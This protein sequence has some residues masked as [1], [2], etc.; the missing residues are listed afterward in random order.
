VL[1]YR[2]VFFADRQNEGILSCKWMTSSRWFVPWLCKDWLRNQ[3]DSHPVTPNI[4]GMHLMFLHSH[5]MNLPM[6]RAP[7]M[8][9]RPFLIVFTLPIRTEKRIRCIHRP[10]IC[11]MVGRYTNAPKDSSKRKSLSSD[12]HVQPVYKGS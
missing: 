8:P 11:I 12:T 5:Y 2:A 4:W 3:T 10:L 9:C 6:I 7:D 1:C